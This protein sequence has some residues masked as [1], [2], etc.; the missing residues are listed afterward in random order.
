MKDF[1]TTTMTIGKNNYE[2][3][4]GKCSCT[5]YR[6]STKATLWRVPEKMF[7]FKN[8]EDKRQQVL[9]FYTRESD[10]L[11]R[12]EQRRQERLQ[13]NREHKRKT[14]AQ[15]IKED[16]QK[17]FP[18]VKFSCKY[19]T[20]SWGD[21]VNV[22]WSGGPLKCEVEP[23][24]NSY[25]YWHFDGMTDMYEYYEDRS[26]PMEQ[27]VKYSRCERYEDE[28][29]TK[30]WMNNLWYTAEQLLND[31]K[32]IADYDKTW[33]I[34]R[35]IA[36]RLNEDKNNKWENRSSDLERKHEEIGYIIARYII[37]NIYYA[38]K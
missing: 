38:K 25:E 26:R 20:F 2:L 1:E 30:Q 11:K 33:C 32:D 6:L 5:I 8:E 23:V 17:R 28:E 21:D 34:A 18:W 31:V 15:Y 7:Y 13:Y 24:V 19:K 27:C 3:V 9:D 36:R 12:K 16:L 29:E 37:N 22:S 10:R 14:P 4:F 35:R